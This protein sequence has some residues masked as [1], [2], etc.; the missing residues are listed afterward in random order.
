MV[1]YDKCYQSFRFV[2]QFVLNIMF[3]YREKDSSIT[4]P[5]RVARN[6]PRGVPA[7]GKTC[8]P[9]GSFFSPVLPSGHFFSKGC[10]RAPFAHPLAT[11]LTYPVIWRCGVSYRR[12][13]CECGGCASLKEMI[14]L[15]WETTT[16]PNFGICNTT[17]GRHRFRSKT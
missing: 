2:K 8:R 7:S 9:C 1:R 11:P 15:Q 12:C 16:S 14:H 4:Y 6:F 17:R 10:A 3:K 5:R 13:G